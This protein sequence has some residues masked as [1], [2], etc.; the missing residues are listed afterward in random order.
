MSPHPQ[1][2]VSQLMVSSN[3]NKNSTY[4]S[5]SANDFNRHNIYSHNAIKRTVV[6][7]QH[8][9]NQKRKNEYHLENDEN[10]YSYY[11]LQKNVDIM[12]VND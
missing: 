10:S 9:I 1:I 12:G 7:I 11:D 5:L 6:P 3:N 2:K 4:P 8:Q